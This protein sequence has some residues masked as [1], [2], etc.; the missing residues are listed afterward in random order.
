MVS[1]AGYLYLF[2][3]IAAGTFALLISVRFLGDMSNHRL[4]LGAFTTLSLFRLVIS[5]AILLSVLIA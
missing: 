3:V 1:P 5:A 4:A 2:L